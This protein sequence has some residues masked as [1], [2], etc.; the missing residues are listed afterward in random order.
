MGEVSEKVYKLVERFGSTILFIFFLLELLITSSIWIT[1]KITFELGFG[2]IFLLNIY[3]LILYLI[4]LVAKWKNP[5]KHEYTIII[6]FYL[7]II[8]W[9]I[10]RMMDYFEFNILLFN[11]VLGY[12]GVLMSIIY[13]LPNPKPKRDS[14]ISIIRFALSIIMVLLSIL[15]F[16]WVLIFP[17][18]LLPLIPP[19]MQM[20]L[21]IFYI[22]LFVA[23]LILKFKPETKEVSH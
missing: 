21:L 8:F 22:A 10:S 4:N 7:S 3:V 5:N 19:E 23:L 12:L 9:G 15:I 14:P 18:A 16:I 11:L 20:S 1:E 13:L 2:N 17:P 6:D